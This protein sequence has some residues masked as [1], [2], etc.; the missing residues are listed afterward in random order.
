MNYYIDDYI[1]DYLEN[2]LKSD[3]SGI[4]EK[5]YIHLRKYGISLEIPY[6]LTLQIDILES[7]L[8]TFV[9]TFIRVFIYYF[10]V[11]KKKKNSKLNL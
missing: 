4:T 2:E 6:R 7:V 1:E 9:E 3:I 11:K 5:D 10:P 8:C